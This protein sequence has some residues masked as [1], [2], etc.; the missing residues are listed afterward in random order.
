VFAVVIFIHVLVALFRA[1][2][3]RIVI[4]LTLFFLINEVD[5]CASLVPLAPP[6]VRGD[7][8]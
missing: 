4:I 1:F 8:K 7:I 3:K 6:T 2:M 5:S